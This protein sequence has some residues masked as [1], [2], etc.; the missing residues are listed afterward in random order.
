[1]KTQSLLF[2]LGFLIVLPMISLGQ[3]ETDNLLKSKS[4]SANNG[5]KKGAFH[6]GIQDIRVNF[7]GNGRT[8]FSISP[9][10]GYMLSDK[11]MIFADAYFSELFV[12]DRVKNLEFA[13]NYRRY[14]GKSALKPFVQAG[15][16]YGY[17]KFPDYDSTPGREDEYYVGNI[18][19]G[20]SYR[21]KRWSFETGLQLNYNQIHNNNISLK[22]MFGVS[23]SF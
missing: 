20:V 23:F 3:N 11:D 18:G 16:G 2:I 4:S 21:Y 13:L 8:Y 5:P 22:P 14:F 7:Y 1:M 17:I 6:I 9:R 12:N 10:I 19:A 15:M